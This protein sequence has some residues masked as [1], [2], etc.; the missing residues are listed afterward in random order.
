MIS[1]VVTSTVTTV[2]ALGVSAALGVGALILAIIFLIT[3]ELTAQAK[4]GSRARRLSKFINVGIVPLM[5]VFLVIVSIK[6]M[7]ALG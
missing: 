7:Q 1:T 2:T 5:M 6:I 3:K 4:E